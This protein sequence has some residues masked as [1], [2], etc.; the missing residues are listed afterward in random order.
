M[1]IGERVKAR[2]QQ[3]GWTQA[4]LAD[5]ANMAQTTV[6]TIEG[7]TKR[8]DVITLNDIAK[9]LGVTVDDLLTEEVKS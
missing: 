4:K 9:A 2:R 7:R 5:E 1:T 8:P 6:S 3:L